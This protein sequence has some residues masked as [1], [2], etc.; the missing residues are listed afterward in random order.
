MDFKVNVSIR[1]RPLNSSEIAKNC[2]V[3]IRINDN[4]IEMIKLK[5]NEEKCYT[6]KFDH[7]HYPDNWTNPIQNNQEI[8]Y[9]NIG[10]KMINYVFDGYNVCIFA[11]GQTASGKTYTMMGEPPQ[12]GIIPRFCKELI[13]TLQSDNNDA[14]TI[15]ISYFEI[16]CEQVHDLIKTKNKKNLKV[17]E[18]PT[19][20][21]YVENLSKVFVKTSKDILDIINAGHKSR[22]VASTLANEASSRSH[23]ILALLVTHIKKDGK[24]TAIEK[25]SKISLVDLAGSENVRNTGAFGTR[26]KE[27]SHINKSLSTLGI[28]KQKSNNQY[29]PYR[30]SILTWLL[31]DN[32]GGN[33]RTSMIGTISPA[34]INF[35]ETLSTLRYTN[36]AKNIICKAYVNKGGNKNIINELKKEI[37]TLKEKLGKKSLELEMSKMEE[38]NYLSR[39]L[40]NEYIIQQLKEPQYHIEQLHD[41]L[42]ERKAF[43]ENEIIENVKI[44]QESINS[45]KKNSNVD[46]TDAF[47]I[48]TIKKW[49][50]YKYNSFKDEIKTILKDIFQINNFSRIYNQNVLFK[51]YAVNKSI[52]SKIYCRDLQ[53]IKYFNDYGL[54]ITVTNQNIN[55]VSYWSISKLKERLRYI[56]NVI[57]SNDQVEDPDTSEFIDNNIFKIRKKICN[58]FQIN[59]NTFKPPQSNQ[60][61]LSNIS[62]DCQIN[63]NHNQPKK[64][65]KFKDICH[66]AIRTEKKKFSR[67]QY[68]GRSLLLCNKFV[69]INNQKYSVIDL[70]GQLL[71]NITINLKKI[72]ND[73]N[74]LEIINM[75]IFNTIYQ[76]FY[77]KISRTSDVIDQYTLNLSLQISQI[78]TSEQYEPVHIMEIQENEP[79]FI[80]K[81]GLQGIL[82]LF[83]SQQNGKLAIINNISSVFIGRKIYDKNNKYTLGLDEMDKTKLIQLHPRYNKNK[84]VNSSWTTMYEATWENV[85]ALFIDSEKSAKLNTILNLTIYIDLEIKNCVSMTCLS[86]DVNIYVQNRFKKSLS[87]Q[88]LLF[89]TIF[90]FT[91]DDRYNH[92]C[93]TILFEIIVSKYDPR[94][95]KAL[96]ENRKLPYKIE[97]NPDSQIVDDLLCAKIITNMRFIYEKM[98]YYQEVQLTNLRLKTM[99][100]KL[101]NAVKLKLNQ[102]V[103]YDNLTLFNDL[104]YTY[105]IN[106]LNVFDNESLTISAMNSLINNMSSKS[107]IKETQA[108]YID[109]KCMIRSTSLPVFTNQ[110]FN[111]FEM[112]MNRNEKPTNQTCLESYIADIMYI[113]VHEKVTYKGYISIMMNDRSKW[114][115]KYVKIDNHYM[116]FFDSFDKKNVDLIINLSVS[117]VDYT[118][119]K[120]NMKFKIKTSGM[121]IH[122]R[123]KNEENLNYWLQA[124]HPLFSGQFRKYSIKQV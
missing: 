23:A 15:Q 81:Q 119:L 105:K 40:E 90:N 84:L 75:S 114:I 25:T 60:T 59:L 11:Y 112:K 53:S 118:P 96:N 111:N 122:F 2:N 4:I 21:I 71:G 93:T 76:D 107:N 82:S 28:I 64:N 86:A 78:N 3:S 80:L 121:C 6:F 35:E 42:N 55:S 101:E 58:L 109:T 83:I 62:Q 45:L 94:F 79:I 100:I 17:R 72:K 66:Q 104:E 48:K 10:K 36:T 106:A 26:L 38:Q 73:E 85:H 113:N 88:S 14:W 97:F 57:Q 19:Y 29:I 34:C 67:F 9:R 98:K 27:G 61:N 8:I 70:N 91:H 54:I 116:L 16:Y 95:K 120:I 20:G 30:D 5:N 110:S 33:C 123:A 44:N 50:N 51:L 32:L 24:K 49:K 46:I 41:T 22:A 124:L 7:C 52:Y 102:S 43:I 74:T 63:K 87:F 18:H 37:N 39:L 31:K 12:E 68:V 103:S 99:N 115:T 56:E 13:H 92:K 89:S 108:T 47:L 69:E 65:E 117:T 77:F 1:V